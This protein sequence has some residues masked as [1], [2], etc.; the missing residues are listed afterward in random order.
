MFQL[1]WRNQCHSVPYRHLVFPALLNEP[2]APSPS[3]WCTHLSC[4]V[5]LDVWICFRDLDP[6]PIKG[7]LVFSN[8]QHA[9]SWFLNL[10]TWYKYS[11]HPQSQATDLM[12]QSR[13]GERCSQLT[14][15]RKWARVC[16]GLIANFLNFCALIPGRVILLALLFSS[17]ETCQLLIFCIFI[18]ILES[19]YHIFVF[20]MDYLYLH[21]NYS[22]PI[23]F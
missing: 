21:W 14:L 1:W 23:N 8:Q 13:V 5:S 20:L 9:K 3:T 15:C 16:V 6:S 22:Y 7:V 10:L 17:N 19:A 2:S 18:Q 11:H 4:S 12:S